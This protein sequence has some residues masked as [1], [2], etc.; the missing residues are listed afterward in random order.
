M[1][2]T[3]I[4]SKLFTVEEVAE[5]YVLGRASVNDLARA[6]SDYHRATQTT[7]D[8]QMVLAYRETI[9]MTAAA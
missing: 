6:I 8:H 1:S 9:T 3:E 2:D 5:D 4:I 7:P